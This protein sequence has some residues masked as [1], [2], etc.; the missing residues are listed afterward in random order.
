MYPN[1]NLND[2]LHLSLPEANNALSCF[3]LKYPSL[4]PFVGKV[5]YSLKKNLQAYIRSTK[6]PRE[7][8]FYSLNRKTYFGCFYK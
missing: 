6:Q 1:L 5:T 2:K 7:T 8:T 4:F 3:P